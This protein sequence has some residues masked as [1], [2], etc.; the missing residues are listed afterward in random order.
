MY[1]IWNNR[2]WGA[3]R[4]ADGWRPYLD[5][6]SATSKADDT[7]C[8]RDHLHVSLSWEGAMG[9]TSY[10]TDRVADRDYGPCRART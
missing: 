4:A 2:I 3:Y 1:L 6:A 7:R 9:R 5:C 8:H 10:W